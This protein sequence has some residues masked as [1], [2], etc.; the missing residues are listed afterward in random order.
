MT[1][2]Y[3]NYIQKINF[4]ALIFWPGTSKDFLSLQSYIFTC[5]MRKPLKL[6]V[7][8]AWKCLKSQRAMIF[9]FFVWLQNNYMKKIWKTAERQKRTI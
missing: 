9:L 8:M 3:R 4:S 6:Q 2:S 5:K 1:T 7:L